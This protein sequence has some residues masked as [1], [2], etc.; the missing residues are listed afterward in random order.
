SSQHSNSNRFHHLIGSRALRERSHPELPANSESPVK[1]P[2]DGG[3]TTGAECT[4]DSGLRH[5]TSPPVLSLRCTTTSQT[6]M[7][8]ACDGH[9]GRAAGTEARGGLTRFLTRYKHHGSRR[10][11]REGYANL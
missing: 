3:R 6:M 1:R 8:A 9:C 4:G 5:R 2:R 11:A 7:C 10:Q